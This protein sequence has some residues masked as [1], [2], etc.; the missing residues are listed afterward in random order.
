VALTAL[1]S[2]APLKDDKLWAGSFGTDGH[3]VPCPYKI[4]VVVSTLARR[5]R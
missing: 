2:F 4:L 5:V 3:G 1:R